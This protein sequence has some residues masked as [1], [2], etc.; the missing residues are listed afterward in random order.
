MM[1]VGGTT[2]RLADSAVK[3][4][5]VIIQN[6]KD[7]LKWGECQKQSQIKYDYVQNLNA[8]KLEKK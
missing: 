2:K 8:T 3:R 1:G 6:A 4:Q 7:F 5:T